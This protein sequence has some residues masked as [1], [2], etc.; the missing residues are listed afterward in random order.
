MLVLEPAVDDDEWTAICSAAG[1]KILCLCA[2]AGPLKVLQVR[3]RI[4]KL[5][6]CFSEK[7]SSG[8]SNYGRLEPWK[9]ASNL[10]GTFFKY[11]GMVP[12]AFTLSQFLGH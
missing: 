10:S 4:L 8:Q 5:I 3:T 12:Q 2:G 1:E 9:Q 6:F 7:Q 11:L